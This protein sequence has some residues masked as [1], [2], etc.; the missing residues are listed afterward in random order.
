VELP[1]LASL[2]A[3]LHG[4]KISAHISIAKKVI[5]VGHSWG[6]QLT[7]I[8]AASPLSSSLSD[9]LILTGYSQ[10]LT[11]QPLFLASTAFNLASTNQQHRFRH[12]SSGY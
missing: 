3:T 12:R 2:T 5:H 10:L 6:S 8:L 1:L 11:Y 7:N 4:G 9:S